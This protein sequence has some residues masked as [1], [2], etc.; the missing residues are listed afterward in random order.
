MFYSSLVF[1]LLSF[2]VYTN[3]DAIVLF[4]AGFLYLLFWCYQKRV[5]TL[6]EELEPI[7]E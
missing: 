3:V 4:L 5:R 2:T 6:S 1:R 7:R